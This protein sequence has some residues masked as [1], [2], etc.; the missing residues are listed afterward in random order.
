MRPSWN[1]I[2]TWAGIFSV[3]VGLGIANAHSSP[4]GRDAQSSPSTTTDTGD[5]DFVLHAAMSNMA[6]IQFGHLAAKKSQHAD[7]KKFAQATIDEH[8]KAQQQLADAAYGAGIQWPKKLD[9]KHQQTQQRLSK[10]TDEQFDREFM[11]AMVDRHRDAEKLLAARVSKS[12]ASS[13]ELAEKV[14]QW[15][16]RTL[17]DV[18][19]HLKEAERVYGAFSKGE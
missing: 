8:L 11:K 14:D 16:A 4:S 12:A 10:L 3:A 6:A 13:N 18:R 2:V 15:A 9:E 5:H 1:A 19:A 7:V 17:P